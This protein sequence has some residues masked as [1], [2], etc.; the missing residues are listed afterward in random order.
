LE[1]LSKQVKEVSM[2]EIV[3]HMVNTHPA[4]NN[5]ELAMKVMSQVNPAIFD[6]EDYWKRLADLIKD[7]E[8][9]ELEYVLPIHDYRIKSLYFP[10]GT[11]FGPR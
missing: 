6:V 3:L 4:I 10:K 2:K 11:T 8:I 7:G 9:I 1:G 5:V